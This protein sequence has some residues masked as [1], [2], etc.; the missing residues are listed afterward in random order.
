MDTRGPDLGITIP[1]F[2]VCDRATVTN[3]MEL[4]QGM[5]NPWNRR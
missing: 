3:S 1:N 2:N 5:N 4:S